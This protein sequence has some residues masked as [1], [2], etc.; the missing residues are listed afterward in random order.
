M[1]STVAAIKTEIVQKQPLNFYGYTLNYKERHIEHNF[2]QV[3]LFME[4][5]SLLYRIDLRNEKFNFGSDRRC[6]RNANAIR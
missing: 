2:L 1:F 3:S 5:C 6:Q 4:L